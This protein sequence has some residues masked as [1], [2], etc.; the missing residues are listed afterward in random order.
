MTDFVG[1][2]SSLN[3]SFQMVIKVKKGLTV[4]AKLELLS[5]S[6]HLTFCPMVLTCCPKQ[7]SDQSK[8]VKVLSIRRGIEPA[9]SGW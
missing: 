5:S 9:T 8:L 4:K 7:G 6:Y 1:K 3:H 2:R